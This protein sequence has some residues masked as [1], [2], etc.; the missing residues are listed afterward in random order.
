MDKVAR[1]RHAVELLVTRHA[2]FRPSHGNIETIPI[3]DVTHGN[4]LLLDVGWDSTGRVYAV[5]FHIRLRDGKVWIEW[6]GTEPGIASELMEAGI[7]KEDIV[8]AF[9]R[10][11]RRAITGF[12]VA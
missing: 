11:E 10:A 9:Y 5:V 7:P 4:Y 3:C 2:E 12:A 1:Y 8:L 6:D